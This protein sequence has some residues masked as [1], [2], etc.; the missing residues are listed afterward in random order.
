MDEN[1]EI[2][3]ISPVYNESDNIEIFINICININFLA[4]T[5]H[6]VITTRGTNAQVDSFAT[7]STKL[8]KLSLAFIA[9]I[10]PSNYRQNII[11]I[12]MN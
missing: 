10:E 1:I 7:A 4:I 3:I 9:S 6:I 5:S 11:V 12:I 8:L 2:S